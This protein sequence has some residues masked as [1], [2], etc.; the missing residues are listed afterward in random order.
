MSEKEEEK[1]L[2]EL[3]ASLASA[4]N[5][6]LRNAKAVDAVMSKIKSK[7]FTVELALIAHIAMYKKDKTKLLVKDTELLNSKTFPLTPEFN[8]EDMEF[9]KKY[10]ISVPD[11][12]TNS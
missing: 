2:N 7:G 10:R 3:V 11:D 9:L 6:A 8:A 1:E 4:I 12:G 5:K